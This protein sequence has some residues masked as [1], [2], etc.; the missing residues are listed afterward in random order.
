MHFIIEGIELLLL[1]LVDLII[2]IPIHPDAHTL[3]LSFA[4]FTRLSILWLTVRA[5]AVLEGCEE[6][7]VPRSQRKSETH[8]A[9]VRVSAV[10]AR[11]LSSTVL[12]S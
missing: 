7:I 12:L 5:E 1:D 8:N 2:C 6:A 3:T 9:R 11:P 4:L 10:L